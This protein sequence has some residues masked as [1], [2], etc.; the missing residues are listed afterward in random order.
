MN[1]LL[2]S[3]CPPY[4]LHLGDRLIIWHLVRELT[5][6]GHTVDLLAFAQRP[7]DHDE[8]DEYAHLFAQVTLIDEPQRTPGHY[9]RRIV[10][11]SARFP[12]QREVSWSS[13]MWDAITA[14]LAAHTVDVVHLFGSVQVYEFAALLTDYPTVITPYESYS[15]YLKRSIEQG[16]GWLDRGR[17][18]VAAAFERFMFNPFGAVVVVAEPDRDELLRHN[19]ALD[20][21]VISNGVDLDYFTA[22]SQLRDAHTLLFTGNYEYAPNV[23]AARYL[24]T[25]IFPQV[26]AH[27]PTTRLEIVGNAPP[28]ELTALASDNVTV[29]GRVPDM[30]PYL[31]RATLFVCPLRV[32][33]GI[34]NK[35]LEALAMGVP[36]VA[37]PLSVDGIAVDEQSAFVVDE[38]EMAA[39]IVK[40]LEDAPRR[41][42]LSE[43]GRQLIEQRYSW[44]RVAA[45]YAALYQQQIERKRKS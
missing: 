42:V 27:F 18:R 1:V 6:Q 5:A 13:A 21:R 2:I 26:K 37:T 45:D 14:H 10:Q 12:Q 15:L 25:H 23:D 3:R 32:G 31:S 40:L 24:I 19:P 39:E 28:P 36:V 16:G 4:P 9:L 34:K 43:Q 11:P 17:Q 20:V 8:I 30:R 41:R 33:A 35:V 22:G 29:T 7:E 44:S 38:R